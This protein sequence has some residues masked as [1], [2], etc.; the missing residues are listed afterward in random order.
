MPQIDAELHAIARLISS[1]STDDSASRLL[2]GLA[3]GQTVESVLLPRGGLAGTV[4][5]LLL[6]IPYALLL[7]VLGRNT[8]ARAFYEKTGWVN[9]GD[10]PY[11][12]EAWGEKFISPCRRY[13][14][15]VR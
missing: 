7:G 2:V 6:G 14:K 3:D 4:G 9:V 15:R 5:L 12:V 13:E 11:E 8:R 1:H 10:L